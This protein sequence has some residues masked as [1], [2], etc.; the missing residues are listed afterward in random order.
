VTEEN[1][2]ESDEAKRNKL[3]EMADGKSLILFYT[4]HNI[5]HAPVTHQSVTR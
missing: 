3:N 2:E 1:Y 4:Y 5:W